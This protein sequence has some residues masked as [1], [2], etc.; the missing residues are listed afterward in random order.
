MPD[1][2]NISMDELFTATRGK[3]E[4][5]RSYGDKHKGPYP[6]Y[7]A[8][9]S[10]PLCFIDTHDYDGSYLTWTT[11]GY[12]GRVQII[13]GKFSIN[14][15]RGVL[16]PKVPTPPLKYLQHILE[17]AL[18][19]AAVGRKVDGRKNEYTKVSPEIVRETVLSLPITAKGD[20]DL[21]QMDLAA[22]KISQISNLQDSLR[23]YNEQIAETEVFIPP[24]GQCA[25]LSLGDKSIF[26]LEIG[27]RVLKKD[28]LIK[29]IPLYSANVYTPFAYVTESN[30]KV[31]DRES[32]LW[33]IDNT[34]FDWNW[35]SKGKQFATT[36]HCG[37]MQINSDELDSEYVFHYLQATRLQYGFDRV[38]RSSLENIRNFVTLAVPLKANGKFDLSA[39]KKLAE[40][41]RKLADLKRDAVQALSQLE[42]AKPNFIL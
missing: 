36:D 6:V 35:I 13:S 18:I 7:S 42:K 27:D 12:G 11:N 25:T 32:I 30:L 14:G 3:G 34:N 4:Y 20:L 16:I 31:F 38:F 29:G 9:L 40:R 39:Q 1:T 24:S 21:N 15:D 10:S 2:K 33:A 17:P 8:S 26:S 23:K 37:R 19:D 41:Y 28:A 5:T 22:K